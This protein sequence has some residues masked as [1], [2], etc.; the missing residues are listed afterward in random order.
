MV[1]IFYTRTTKMKENIEVVSKYNPG[2]GGSEYLLLLLF[3]YLN[4]LYPNLNC[5]LL[6]TDESMKENNMIY[7]KDE[8]DAIEKSKEIGTDEF[9]FI[10]KKNDIN[11]YNLLTEKKINGIAW[12]HN[13]ISC[14][15][16]DLLEKCEA[17]KRIV[18]VGKE[19]YDS[20]IDSK[21]IN[22]SCY[23][24]NMISDVKHDFIDP[25]KKENIVTYIG[26]I[27]PAKGF[28][29]LA[30]VW[31][32]I[33]KEVPDAKLQVIGSGRLYYNDM[34]LGKYNIADE[35]YE[36]RFI[37]YLIDKQ[38]NVI[39]SVKFL[40]T[41]GK[42]KEEYIANTKV[43][44]ANP[45][46]VSETFCLS[47]VEYKTYGIPIVTYKGYGLLDTIRDGVD[48]IL[49][50]NKRQLKKSII[51]LLKDDELNKDLGN[52]GYNDGF[53]CFLP[54]NI[55]QKWVEVLNEVN[56]GL[57]PK[58][59]FPNKNYFNDLKWLK[60]I[61]YKLKEAFHIKNNGIAYTISKI[62][63]YIKKLIHF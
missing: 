5:K 34:K 6:T 31:K 4:L 45:T 41:M 15:I 22:K 37:K 9:I 16:M 30:S 36:K 56:L 40:G 3:Y 57:K 46:G 2:M 54:A 17:I 8:F 28:H 51:K 18:F 53:Q 21:I 24:Y 59:E 14:E 60:I 48:G 26:S 25:S 38:G 44:V 43:G 62:K 35:K 63:M 7:V 58:I 12:I 32:D 20:Y 13:Y 55:I 19:Q 50:K 27:I 29:M 42:E 1:S 61:N 39:D 47:A 49:I 23:I 52:N 10:P 11:F 33:I